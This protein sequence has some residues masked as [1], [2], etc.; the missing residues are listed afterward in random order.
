MTFAQLSPAPSTTSSISKLLPKL[1]L[2]ILLVCQQIR[3]L[4]PRTSSAVWLKFS[5]VINSSGEIPPCF[6]VRSDEVEGCCSVP[7]SQFISMDDHIRELTVME[8]DFF[9]SLCTQIFHD[10]IK[11]SENLDEP[12]ATVLFNKWRFA[13]YGAKVGCPNCLVLFLKGSC[14]QKHST[15]CPTSS[16]VIHL[17]MNQQYLFVNCIHPQSN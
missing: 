15:N 16:S 2:V 11:V 4:C 8:V 17:P 13:K 3:G 7:K 1:P 9:N 6:A 5:I 12:S 10:A 14:C